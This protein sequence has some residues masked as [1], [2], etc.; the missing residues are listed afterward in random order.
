MRFALGEALEAGMVERHGAEH[1]SSFS[2]TPTGVRWMKSNFSIR[3]E[4]KLAFVAKHSRISLKDNK[5][6]EK[7][8]SSM[9]EGH[10]VDWTKWGT[11]FAGI[12]IIL[13]L[14]ALIF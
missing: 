10:R 8:I 9:K 5:N 2:I 11:I 4:P 6:I 3:R 13:A 14:L 1:A 7:M 12:G